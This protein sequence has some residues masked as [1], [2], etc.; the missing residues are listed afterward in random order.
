MR[1]FPLRLQ[2]LLSMPYAV[3]L[4]QMSTILKSLSF[5]LF[6]IGEVI[7]L[8]RKG[9]ISTL[10]LELVERAGLRCL[11]GPIR[12]NKRKTDDSLSPGFEAMKSCALST[13]VNGLL[14]YILISYSEFINRH[15][16][17]DATSYTRGAP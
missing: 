15:F 9:K 6:I 8:L 13:T 5:D 3:P 12:R 17:R 4:K 11:N 2:V 1:G 14:C 10:L 7:S 16:E